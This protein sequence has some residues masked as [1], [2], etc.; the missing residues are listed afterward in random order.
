VRLLITRPDPDGERTASRLRVRGHEVLLTPLLAVEAV[1]DADLDRCQW[2]ALALTSANAVRAL[3]QHPA[4]ARCLTLPVFAVGRRTVEAAR[5]AGFADVTSADGARSDLVH[6]IAARCSDSA[7]LL[8]LAGEDRAGDIG[9]ELAAAGVALETVVIYRAT[10]LTVFP[11]AAHAALE[12]G[13]LEGVLHFSRRSSEAF[14]DCAAAANLTGAAF[15][16]VHFCLSQNVAE[17]LATAGAT[18]IRVAKRPEEAALIDIVT[19]V[20]AKP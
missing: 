12:A 3:A 2:S 5:A 18:R 7:R 16:L 13:A 20:V 4:R 6:L 19:G 17:P 11:L 14:L 8:Y 9:A 10:K 1:L 15:R